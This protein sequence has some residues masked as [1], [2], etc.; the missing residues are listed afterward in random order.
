[1]LI[2]VGREEH[3]RAFVAAAERDS[4]VPGPDGDIG[5]RIVRARQILIF[6]KVA[7]EHVEL[8]LG[9]HRIAVDRIFE[10]RRSVGE[11][12]AEAAAE[13][14]R[15]ADL[16][17][18]PGKSLRARPAGGREELTELLG[19]IKEDRTRFEHSDRLGSAAVNEGGDLRIRVD[20]NEAASE[21]LAIADSD[22]PGIIFRVLV[23]L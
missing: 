7:V 11:E 10:L 12:M 14:R 19:K 16:P 8:S 9:L 22:R 2:F 17:H 5:D 23:A 1:M 21:L 18:Q 6:S 15:G 4:A 3:V 20:R 13:E